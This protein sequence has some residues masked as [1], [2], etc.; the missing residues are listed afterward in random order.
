MSA[1]SHASAVD[2]SLG[3]ANT[4]SY[5]VPAV[6]DGWPYAAAGTPP[7]WL[8]PAPRSTPSYCPIH[9]MLTASRKSAL[10]HQRYRG[11]RK[12][13]P[14][15]D[16][17]IA[18]NTA[19]TFPRA[20]DALASLCYEELQAIARRE[21]RYAQDLATLDTS[22]VVHEAFLRLVS[23]R[24]LAEA[25]RV[26]FLAAAAVTMRRVIIDYARR[27]KA[28]K[29]GG[30]AVPL[31]LDTAPGIVETPRRHAAGLDEALERLSAV[32]PDWCRSW[33]A[34]L[35]GMTEETA[36]VLGVTART[37]RRDWVSARVAHSA[38]GDVTPPVCWWRRVTGWRGHGG[39]HRRR[40]ARPPEHEQAALV[41]RWRATML[42]CE[43]AL[44]C[45]R[46]G[47]TAPMRQPPA[48]TSAR[49]ACCVSW[50]A[51]WGWCI[52]WSAPTDHPCAP[53]SSVAARRRA[54][55]AHGVR[56]FPRAAHLA[57]RH[58]GIARCSTAASRPTAP[59]SHGTSM[60]SPSTTGA[61]TTPRRAGTGAAHVARARCR[62]ARARGWWCLGIGLNNVLVAEDGVPR[63]LDFGIPSCSPDEATET[64]RARCIDDDP[65]RRRA[66]VAAPPLAGARGAGTAGDVHLGVLLY[67]LLTGVLPY[68]DDH[69][70]R[71]ALGAHPGR[72]APG[73]RSS[74]RRSGPRPPG[75]S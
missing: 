24:Q 51:A 6:A 56:H 62:A 70:G 59:C 7:P 29:R 10:T 4:L 52:S 12:S 42:P 23:Q 68:G 46:R 65:G 32:E 19:T 17:A 36:E 49:G 5:R 34:V 63:L 1:F 53:R 2:W 50:G 41:A 37:V 33:N 73:R 22:A 47:P 48:P 45:T 11:W 27:Q 16:I 67:E 71:A 21:R 58:P 72:L 20:I 54:L 13:V 43:A 8:P 30:S 44:K 61:N 64:G 55:D 66:Y 69:D 60:A 74:C 3:P 9:R 15:A 57:F 14:K 35:H 39:A 31:S 25:D 28:E 26:Q 38:L 75:W 40:G 18:M